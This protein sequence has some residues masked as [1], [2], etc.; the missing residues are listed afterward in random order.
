[1]RYRP[2]ELREPII[3]QRETLTSDG[4]GGNAVSV[5][6]LYSTKAMVKPLTGNEHN[7]WDQVSASFGYLFVIRARALLE[8]DR[9]VWRGASYN[10]RSIATEGSKAL[11]LEIQTERGVAL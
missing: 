4:M 2:G 7:N 9:I 1:M 8:T 3:I 5:A 11:Y 10:I 6:T